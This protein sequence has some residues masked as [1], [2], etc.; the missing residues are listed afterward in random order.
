MLMFLVRAALPQEPLEF[1]WVI[2]K[3]T[4][5]RMEASRVSREILGGGSSATADDAVRVRISE[6]R[7]GIT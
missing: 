6:A 1:W 4:P 5:R 7:M 2:R 3:S